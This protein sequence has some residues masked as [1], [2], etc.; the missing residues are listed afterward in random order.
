MQLC[1]TSFNSL[2][3][4]AIM[5]LFWKL[6]SQT[7]LIFEVILHVI[8]SKFINQK[9]FSR[10]DVSTVM[11]IVFSHPYQITVKIDV[12]FYNKLGGS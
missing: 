12:A 8:L 7:L 10:L 4:A 1:S 3:F 9:Y 2:P 6:G 5:T 11:L